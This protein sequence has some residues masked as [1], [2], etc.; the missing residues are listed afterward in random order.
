MDWGEGVIE[1]LEREI[2]EELGIKPVVGRLQYVSTFSGR[3]IHT[4]EFFFEVLNAKDY[5][6]VDAESPT[7]AFEIAEMH[8]VKPDT[9]IKIL[10]KDMGQ[11]FASGA[12]LSDTVRFMKD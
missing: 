4:T 12:L 6:R 7:H 9:K 2:V 11:D 8:W 10:P 5:R 1:C 3:D